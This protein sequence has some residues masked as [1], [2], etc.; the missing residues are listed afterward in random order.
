MV[1][2]TL[3]ILHLILLDSV[4]V[5]VCGPAPLLGCRPIRVRVSCVSIYCSPPLCNTSIVHHSTWYQ[6]IRFRVSPSPPTA[7][8]HPI[9]AASPRTSRRPP[10]GSSVPP[11][12]GLPP[13]SRA[14][15]LQQH[16]HGAQFADRRSLPFHGTSL[17]SLVWPPSLPTSAGSGATMARLLRP[18]AALTRARGLRPDAVQRGC[19]QAW[20]PRC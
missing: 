9:A 17:C 18:G 15:L 10:G 20:R 11:G 4:C 3:T 5:S 6:R 13:L 2:R 12:G 7:V 16:P 1:V 8:T 19:V 14:L